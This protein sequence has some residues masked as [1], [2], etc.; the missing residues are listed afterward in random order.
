MEIFTIIFLAVLIASVITQLWLAHRHIHYISAH[1]AEVPAEFN[2]KIELGDHQKAADYTT[3][4]TRF[5]RIELIFSS[6]LLL[7]WTLG[8]G[9]NYLNNT[10]VSF[11]MS[12]VMT[13][14]F[15]SFG[16]I[17]I[18]SLLDLPFSYYR[19]FKL[20]QKYEF[21]RTTIGTFISDLVKQFTLMLVIGGPFLWVIFTLVEKSGENWWLYVWLTWFGFSLFMMWAYPAFIAPLFNKFT[22]LDENETKSRIVTLLKKCG[23]ESK[24]VFVMDGSKRSSHGNAYFTGLGKNKRIVFFDTLL[25]SLQPDEI[26]AVLAHEL[27][28]FKRHHIKKRIAIFGITSLISLLLLG[29]LSQQAFFYSSLGVESQMVYLALIL[30]M[31]VSPVFTFFLSPLFALYSRKHEF[32]ADEYAANQSNADKLIT[33]LV[34]LYKENSSTLTPDPVY[35]AF[36]DSHPPA[37]IRIA[38]LRSAN[39]E[40]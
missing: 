33:A 35:S 11:G 32:E 18:S 28:H 12:T 4:K 25:E 38:H 1:R 13:A 27:G 2:T 30:F 37:P 20:E 23:F 31:L 10:I 21:N 3:E 39:L 16:L 9:L 7:I 15:V 17:I 8:G 26:E 14:V 19:T 40:S 22:P 6:I 5:G 24:G 36:Y 34:K 29:W